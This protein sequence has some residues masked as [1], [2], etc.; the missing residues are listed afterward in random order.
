VSSRTAKTIQKEGRWEG[1]RGEGR[2]G[3]ERGG[4]GRGR[5]ERE[6]GRKLLHSLACQ[7]FRRGRLVWRPLSITPDLLLRLSSATPEHRSTLQTGMG[8]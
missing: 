8:G 5:E 1:R 3:E 2:G 7:P 6:G 4:E